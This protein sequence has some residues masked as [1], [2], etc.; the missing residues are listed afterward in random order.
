M[1]DETSNC[2][3][4]VRRNR[5]TGVRSEPSPCTSSA[6]KRMRKLRDLRRCGATICK[7]TLFEDWPGGLVRLGLLT[8]AEVRDPVRLAT[9]VGDFADFAL[10]HAIKLNRP[11]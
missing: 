3:E 6:A 2:T 7:V 11:G 1:T 4:P 8:E 5:E 10:R 9:A